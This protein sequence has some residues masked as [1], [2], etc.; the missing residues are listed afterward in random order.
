MM[1]RGMGRVACVH[2]V[3]ELDSMHTCTA[4]GYGKNRIVVCCMHRDLLVVAPEG[5]KPTSPICLC[6]SVGFTGN[7]LLVLCSY[8]DVTTRCCAVVLLCSCLLHCITF[9]W[10]DPALVNYIIFGLF[11]LFCKVLVFAL[12]IHQTVYYVSALWNAARKCILTQLTGTVVDFWVTIEFQQRLQTVIPHELLHAYTQ[13]GGFAT[14][15]PMFKCVCTC[16]HQHQHLTCMWWNTNW[17]QIAKSTGTYIELYTVNIWFCNVHQCTIV[18]Q[19]YT[20]QTAPTQNR[21]DLTRVSHH[22]SKLKA[23]TF[24]NKNKNLRPITSQN[25]KPFHPYGHPLFF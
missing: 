6:I 12:D 17:D 24:L 20:S 18:F 7:N 25:A 8:A 4:V 10:C 11:W 5:G 14:Q 13:A 3:H 23:C 9:W 21:T 1:G 19:I 16:V 2:C 22:S 15:M